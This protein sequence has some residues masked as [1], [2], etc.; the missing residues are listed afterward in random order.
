MAIERIARAL[1]NVTGG[2][3][4]PP[5]GYEKDHATRINALASRFKLDP[6]RLF[7]AFKLGKE[8]VYL[9]RFNW[10]PERELRDAKQCIQIAQLILDSVARELL[11]T[12][13]RDG[14]LRRLS[15]RQIS[16]IDALIDATE[17]SIIRGVYDHTINNNLD[18]LLDRFLD[19][20]DR[21]ERLRERRVVRLGVQ[22]AWH[23]GRQDAPS[24]I[25]RA[26]ELHQNDKDTFRLRH[27]YKVKAMVDSQQFRFSASAVALAEAQRL[28]KGN[29]EYEHVLRN[30]EAQNLT[31][32]GKITEGL[33]VATRCIQ[34]P[35]LRDLG[36]S[37]VA[38]T[39]A[40][41][42]RLLIF[43]QRYEE[44]EH[45]L[46]ASLEASGV[47]AHHGVRNCYSFLALVHLYR[48]IGDIDKAKEAAIIVSRLS[49]A[50]NLNWHRVALASLQSGKP[51]RNPKLKEAG[52]AV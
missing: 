34:D 29:R 43:A 48:R 45:H 32:E 39:R 9:D 11:P 20:C 1:E 50:A 5:P 52:D 6:A 18:Y 40:T 46:R 3:E 47:D 12:L 51:T 38:T 33:R 28:A 4:K 16:H 31:R 8:G 14:A 7:H 37:E 26:L 23:Q 13:E 42:G 27:I 2:I 44:A 10:T 21:A 19:S 17:S 30:Y 24:V 36:P 41:F 49:T 15:T 35:I 22:R 25:H